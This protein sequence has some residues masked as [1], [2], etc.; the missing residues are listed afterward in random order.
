MF[1]SCNF[2]KTQILANIFE[3][4][5]WKEIISRNFDTTPGGS[6]TRFLS[7]VLSTEYCIVMY[8]HSV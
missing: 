4:I 6:D 8:V 1:D 3:Q 7:T 2:F 5:L